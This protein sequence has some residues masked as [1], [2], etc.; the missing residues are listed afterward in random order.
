MKLEGQ[1]QY[2]NL[3]TVASAPCEREISSVGKAAEMQKLQRFVKRD[4]KVVLV[5]PDRMS[6]QTEVARGGARRHNPTRRGHSIS[7]F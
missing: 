5:Q 3:S 7:L 6:D 4:V 2:I 1:K